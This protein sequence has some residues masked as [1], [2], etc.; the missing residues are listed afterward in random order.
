MSAGRVPSSPAS[1]GG[2]PT[3]SKYLL[4]VADASLPN[5]Q[6]LGAL[7]TGL[8]KSTT[9][10][11]VQSIAVP[12]VDYAKA[13][14]KQFSTVRNG[15]EA[16]P[17]AAQTLSIPVADGENNAFIRAYARL[18]SDGTDRN[19][20]LKINGSATNV[21]FEGGSAVGGT[22]SASASIVGTTGTSVCHVTIE[23]VTKK[24]AGSLKRC[25]NIKVVSCTPGGAEVRTT[26][27]GFHFND[28]TNTI[29]SIDLDC[30]NATGLAAAEAYVEE[31]IFG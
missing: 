25:G 9:A 26:Q 12:G 6:A 21:T 2:A 30:G 17:T 11:G 18:K 28:S 20:T 8:L 3:T 24:G 7:A 15:T 16:S 4:Q 22:A 5:A 14:I 10:T 1:A 13:A 31:G 23:M 29:T 27:G 19:I